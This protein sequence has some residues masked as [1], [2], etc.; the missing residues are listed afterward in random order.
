MSIMKWVI[1]VLISSI[2][3]SCIGSNVIRF[4]KEI[5]NG[6]D[7]EESIKFEISDTI[8][9]SSNISFHVR[10]DNDYPFSNIFLIASLKSSIITSIFSRTSGG[11]TSASK[12]ISGRYL[13]NAFIAASLTNAETSAPTKP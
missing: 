3:T 12:S 2:L 10:N 11:I 1:P 6:W 7:L 4:D 5:L 13:L 8:N 9:F